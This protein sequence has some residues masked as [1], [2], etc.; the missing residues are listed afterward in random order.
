MNKKGINRMKSE[1]EVFQEIEYLQDRLKVFKFQLE[2]KGEKFFLNTKLTSFRFDT[3]SQIHWYLN[4]LED[5][6]MY[7]NGEL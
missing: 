7:R 1:A 3:I 4:G 6:K 5:G 2:A